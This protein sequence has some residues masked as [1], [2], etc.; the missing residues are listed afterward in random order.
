MRNLIYLLATGWC[1]WGMAS[2]GNR[3]Q[4]TGQADFGT[5]I[6]LKHTVRNSD[7][8]ASYPEGFFQL[9]SV[10]VV[11]SPRIGDN[12][13]R[14]ISLKTFQ[15]IGK[16]GAKGKGPTEV[17]WTF[18]FAYT[19]SDST[20][21][22]YDLP[23]RSVI[24][25]TLVNRGDSLTMRA[26]DKRRVDQG[27][28]PLQD[29]TKLCR[30]GDDHY[31]GQCFHAQD[32]FFSLL[33]KDFNQIGYFGNSPIPE[34]ITNAGDRLQGCMNAGYGISIFAPYELPYIGCYA[35]RDGKPVKLW[36]DDFS[37]KIYNINNNR[38]VHDQERGKGTTL[39]TAISPRYIYILW[40]NELIYTY[41]ERSQKGSQPG[42][43]IVFIYDHSGN[44]IAHLV[45]DTELYYLAVSEDDRTLY[46]LTQAEYALV[47]FDLPETYPAIQ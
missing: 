24:S 6:P 45:L 39:Y 28:V 33:D 26:H 23:S 46:G 5:E 18:P 27:D 17:I 8:F 29:N 36:E 44:R 4:P 13:G 31:M 9:D 41:A 22:A 7:I 38:L 43:T 10:F 2:C 30:I 12:F 42:G 37:E 34:S 47:T 15:E 11:L 3:T 20:F 14:L 19:G 16:F 35:M 32:H 40:N 21:M 1:L 25:Y